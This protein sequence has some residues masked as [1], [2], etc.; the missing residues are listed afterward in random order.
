MWKKEYW[1]GGGGGKHCSL[2]ENCRIWNVAGFVGLNTLWVHLIFTQSIF[3]QN[4]QCTR[5]CTNFR[6][7]L[8]HSL[9]PQHWYQVL[10]PQKCSIAKFH[11]ILQSG[12]KKKKQ[13]VIITLGFLGGSVV[14]NLPANAGDAGS[15]TGSGRSLGEGNGNPNQYSCL[16]NSMDRGVWRTTVH[17]VARVGQNLVTKQQVLLHA[18]C[19]ASTTVTNMRPPQRMRGEG[20]TH[21]QMLLKT[22]FSESTWKEH[23]SCPYVLTSGKLHRLKNQ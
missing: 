19:H 3:I 5:L 7:G 13:I 4:L 20:Q 6:G 9:E 12:K 1:D 2:R 16:G 18:R 14:K 23:E 15:T 22:V 10:A 11:G 17:G 21:E 8:Y